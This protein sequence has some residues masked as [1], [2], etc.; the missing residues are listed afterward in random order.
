MRIVF[1][2]PYPGYLRFFGTTME[3]L[4]ERGHD[5]VAAY[6][7]ADSKGH[8]AS[9]PDG[10]RVAPWLPKLSGRRM[11]FLESVGCAADYIRYLE[12]RFDRAAY[13]QARI[14][15]SLPRSARAVT[16]LP[17]MSTRAVSRLLSV[18]RF[19]ERAIPAPAEAV[20]YLRALA[21]DVVVLSPLVLRGPSGGQQTQWAKAAR[22]LGVPVVLAVG[23]WDH[24]S[25][26]GVIRVPLDQVLV[27]NAIQ[28]REAVELHGVPPEHV[29]MTG[30]QPFDH[31]FDA[32]PVLPRNLFFA[33]VGLAPAPDMLLYAGSSK[34]IADPSAE[35]AFVAEWLGAVRRATDERVRHAAVLI[36]PH[37]GN[38]DHWADADLTA[39]GNVAIWPR[40][41][42]AFPLVG[43]DQED[44]LHSLYYAAAVV[45]INTSAMVEAAI[46]E[47]PVL[48]IATPAF[49]STQ[50][51]T[52]HFHY[53]TEQHGGAVEMAAD[54]PTHAA[55]L[56]HALARY[57]AAPAR[58][59]VAAFVRPHGADVSATFRV[60]DAIES[61]GR[62]GGT[63]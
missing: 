26:K 61:A 21:P 43:V 56:A 49:R 32:R 28:K 48:T 8:P 34:G 15:R 42:P 17:R 1:L 6:A 57:D 16:A 59:F 5:V 63:A 62:R 58:A 18:S 22:V 24:L 53:L 46:L 54:L 55:Q 31:W 14:A 7:R 36:R 33:R 4:R 41:R 40:T 23:S 11:R 60:A 20:G 27:W 13:L 44:Y 29:V 25:S 19:A 50:D 3:A 37:P 38:L 47:R 2:L 30:A 10:V 39:H 12:P 9:V 35:R 52:L 45:G 51:G